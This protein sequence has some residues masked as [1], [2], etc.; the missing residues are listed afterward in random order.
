MLPSLK[1]KNLIYD[2]RLPLG[3]YKIGFTVLFVITVMGS[4]GYY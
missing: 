4:I 1:H 3:T 2:L